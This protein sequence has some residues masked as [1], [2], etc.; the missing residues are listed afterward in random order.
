MNDRHWLTQEEIDAAQRELDMSKARDKVWE[1][2]ILGL[3][4]IYL[5]GIF[6]DVFA[7]YLP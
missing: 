3:I 2:I 5:I 7:G 4:A 6:Y 1:K